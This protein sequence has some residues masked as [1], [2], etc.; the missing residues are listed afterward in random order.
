MK[1]Y[2]CVVVALFFGLLSGSLEAQSIQINAPPPLR[3]FIGP[4][5]E[6][7]VKNATSES[8]VLNFGGGKRL[9][10]PGE[11][12][13]FRSWQTHVDLPVYAERC[14]PDH[15]AIFGVP[16]W[17]QDPKIVGP[18][19][20]ED[21]FL[22]AQ[23]TEGEI[24]QRVEAAKRAL[25]AREY[26]GRRE[27]KRALDQWFSRARRGGLRIEVPLCN[28]ETVSAPYRVSFRD[29]GG[30]R[31]GTVLAL[32]IREDGSGRAIVSNR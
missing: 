9:L 10:A 3:L 21:S 2:F 29:S 11:E 17:A 6:V 15:V 12:V 31:Y 7:R 20:I 28:P 4:R 30:H 22:E 26:L 8:Y 23:P 13:A 1:K 24:R 19:T 14:S 5:F 27:M 32:F 16:S 18:H 25:G